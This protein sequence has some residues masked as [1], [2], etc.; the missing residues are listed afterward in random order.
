MEPRWL[1]DGLS[2]H[3]PCMSYYKMFPVS[4]RV[5]WF[6]DWAHQIDNSNMQLTC[7][8]CNSFLFG[9]QMALISNLLGTLRYDSADLPI[10]A[11]IHKHV[12]KK[13]KAC[14][15]PNNVLFVL[16][17][18]GTLFV[19]MKICIFLNPSE[20]NQFWSFVNICSL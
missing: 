8:V 6:G 5:K 11:Q 2:S 3:N 12:E 18:L 1:P 7:K 14:C 19:I 16:F 20:V 9:T 15:H 17:K 4:S 13:F 10:S